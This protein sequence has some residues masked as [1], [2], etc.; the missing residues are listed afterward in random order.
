MHI[1]A[2]AGRGSLQDPLLIVVLARVTA[3]HAQIDDGMNASALMAAQPKLSA[4]FMRSPNSKTYRA[5]FQADAIRVSSSSVVCFSE[6]RRRNRIVS[7]N[8]L[9]QAPARD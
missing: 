2:N 6:L 7:I 8:P 1:C 5:R 9:L 3:P 4:L